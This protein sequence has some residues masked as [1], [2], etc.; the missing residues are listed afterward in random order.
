MLHQFAIHSRKLTNTVWWCMNVWLLLHSD[1]QS[2]CWSPRR[3]S[4]EI[5]ICL[6][7]FCLFACFET[8]SYYASMAGLELII[9]PQLPKCLWSGICHH[10]LENPMSS[11]MNSA[12]TLKI[13]LVFSCF[14][15]ENY[16]LFSHFSIGL[17]IYFLLIWGNLFCNLWRFFPSVHLLLIMKMPNIVKFTSF[18]V[19]SFKGSTLIKTSSN[20]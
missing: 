1:S 4:D 14:Y 2:V 11:V 16:S 5:S 7:G 19:Y 13:R 10:A 20:P 17:L 15:S 3:Q 12:S 18:Y 9:L 8:G 6:F